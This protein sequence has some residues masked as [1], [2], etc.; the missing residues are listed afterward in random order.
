MPASVPER[1]LDPDELLARMRRDEA[2]AQRGLLKIFFGAAPGVGKSYAMLEATRKLAASGVDV[3]VGYVE[4][5]GRPETEALLAGLEVL[6]PQRFEHR[7]M[8]LTEFDVDAALLRHPRAICVDELAHSNHPGAR[9]PKRW[10]DVEELLDAGIDVYT[11]VNV[12]HIESLNDVVAQ[13]T[14]VHVRETVPD[15]VFD[16]ADEVE[17]VDLPP[18]ELLQR[19]REGKVYANEKTGQAL[20]SFFRKGNLIALRQLAL[21]ATADRVD[22]ALREYRESHAIRETWAAG[23]RVLVCVG[24]DPLSERLVRAARRLATALHAGWI[25]VYVETPALPR[26]P[27]GARDRVLATLKLAESLGAETANLSGESVA[28]ELL[29]FA[30]RRNV[31]KILVGKP[32]RSRWHDRLKPSLVDD[33]V[34]QSG[35]IDVYVITG[36]AGA[37]TPRPSRLP[38][39]TSNGPAYAK[40]VAVVAAITLLCA[41]LHKYVEL[42]NLVM[43]Y[44][45]GTVLVAARV[46]RGPSV[47]AAILSVSLF[48]FLFVP[49]IFSFAVSDAQYLITFGVMLATG[50]I[51]SQ[52][53]ARGKRQAAVARARERRTAELYALSRELAQSRDV[54]ALGA[55]L[56]QHVL[57]GIDGE[58]AVLPPDAQGHVQDPTRFCTR[59]SVSTSEARYPVPGNDL[60]IAQ[61]AYDHRQKAGRSSDTLAS[62]DAIY[63]PLNAL[64]RCIGV[65]GLRPR[66]PDQLEIP[67][68]MQLL[69]SFVSQAA[70]AMERVQLAETAQ[71]ADVEIEA[72]KMRNAL[73]SSISHDFR[74][75]LASII[76]AA[77]TLLDDGARG[78]DP[79]QRSALLQTL[80]DEANRLHRLVGNLLDLTRLSSS[81]IPLKR[82]WVALEEIVGAVLRRLQDALAG[83]AIE[84]DLPADLP[85]IEVDEVMI[86]QLLFNLLDNAQKYTPA[87][88][89]IAITAALQRGEIAVSVRDHGPGLPAGEET[90]VFEK[91]HRGHNEAAQSGF[92]LGL[93]IC[94][95]IVAAHGGEISARNLAYGHGD[96]GVE[97]RF[98]LP[99]SAE[100]RA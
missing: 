38:R 63:L 13:I 97:F 60:G 87:G 81:P 34:R 24:P 88:S 14:G 71:A 67:E 47:L 4:L 72:E 82:Q 45:L 84:V 48:D 54:G 74:T 80:L 75:P 1:R 22:A 5:H 39:R 89:A 21:R 33:I 37:E 2:R 8:I 44:L 32:S 35:T 29:A 83:R 94:K 58:A 42:T 66:D 26:L 98:T 23:E 93:S 10:M 77:S 15:R 3:V 90:R 70:V 25:A 52:L 49:P 43:L 57:A 95:A 69:E 99:L 41:F 20:T 64:R 50:L 79:A 12:Q 96:G 31:N 92:G 85:L 51:I 56:C 73:L 19:M 55:I 9:H 11:T 62:A 86:E 18:D 65:L 100:P 78:I 30:R 53:A 27:R 46:G 91:F 76:G 6:A 59:G 17:L 40:S 61:W 28:V 7:G 16:A 68:Q 36:E